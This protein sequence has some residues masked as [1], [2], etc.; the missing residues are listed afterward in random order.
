MIPPREMSSITASSSQEA[1]PYHFGSENRSDLRSKIRRKRR[2]LPHAAQARCAERLAA[3]LAASP[4]FRRSKRIACFFP[5]DGE[6]DLT[7]VFPRFFSMRKKAYLPVLQGKRLWFL[8]LE[9]NTPLTR[10]KYGIPEPDLPPRSRC[11]PQGLDLVLAP[12]VAFDSAGHR[13]GM[14]G[15]YYDR[16]FAYLPHRRALRKPVIIGVAYGFQQVASL[17]ANPWD[18]PL[19]GVVTEAGWVSDPGA[20]SR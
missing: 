18:I 14:G 11:A 17:S 9:A 1:A 19:D 10:N 2:E 7:R 8:P 20:P 5:Q 15:G 16:T 3:H 13:L 6:I 12:L 4:L